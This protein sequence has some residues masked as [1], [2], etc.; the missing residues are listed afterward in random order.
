V[1]DPDR[2]RAEAFAAASG[3]TV[4]AS[5]DEVLDSCDALYVCTWTSEHPRLVAAACERGLAVFCEKPLGVDL[6]TA[7]QMVESVERAGV[8]NQVGLVLRASPAF[9]LLR[10]LVADEASGR[11]MSIV[12]RDDQYIPTQGMYS[13]TWRGDV[14]KAG[15]GALLEHSIHD[16]DMIESVVGPIEA[17]NG[18]TATMH[19][20]D[21]IEDVCVATLALPGGG[22]GTLVSVWHDLLVRPSLRRVEVLCERGFYTLEGDWFGPVSWQREDGSGRLEGGRLVDEVAARGLA[23]PNPDAAFVQAVGE[24]RTATP[25]FR[26]A[27]RAHEVVDAIYR[28]AGRSGAP[29]PVSGG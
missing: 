25:D 22:C 5:E 19:G 24:A 10:S 21:G 3:A 26:A 14:G 4:C 12:F 7:R 6:A 15:S 20:I 11:V 1:F 27:L 8:V 23:E 9:T 28:S 13:S 2:S 16:V 17:V 29:V 18:R